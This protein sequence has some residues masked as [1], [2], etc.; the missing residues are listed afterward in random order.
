MKR[1]ISR[2]EFDALTDKEL[3]EACFAPVVPLIR[4][5]P[6]SVK[7]EVYRSLTDGQRA[8]FMYHVYVDHAKHSAEQFYWW[9]AH[10]AAQPN[11]WAELQRGLNVFGASGLARLM[12]KTKAALA[13]RIG[14]AAPGDPDKDEVLSGTVGALY[15]EFL[16]CTADAAGRIGLAIRANPSDFVA[17]E[18]RDA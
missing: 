16:R 10:Y 2:R 9:T 18:E 5:K 14:D 11:A 15:E 6:D 7:Q 8:L 4:A 13:D 12:D 1:R 17:F 3:G